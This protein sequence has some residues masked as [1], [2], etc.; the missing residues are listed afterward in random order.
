MFLQTWALNKKTDSDRKEWMNP[1]HARY[2]MKGRQK[3][4]ST[5]HGFA[6][7]WFDFVV[8]G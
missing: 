5:F 8:I 3:T 4:H 2:T 7:V 1:Q 6:L